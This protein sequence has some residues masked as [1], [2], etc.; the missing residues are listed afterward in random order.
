IAPGCW[1]VEL[2]LPVTTGVVVVAGNGVLSQ[3][4]A[5]LFGEV[6]EP[7]R[8][9]AGLANAAELRSFRLASFSLLLSGEAMPPSDLD[10]LL[11]VERMVVRVR[12]AG[13]DC[14]LAEA[15]VARYERGQEPVEGEELQFAVVPDLELLPYLECGFELRTEVEGDIP[16]DDVAIEGI[17]DFVMLPA[18]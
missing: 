4:G 8:V 12:P 15:E 18:S 10:D 5:R 14:G 1:S 17:A 6:F 13:P 2:E 11:F 16:P 7:V 3:A 9:D